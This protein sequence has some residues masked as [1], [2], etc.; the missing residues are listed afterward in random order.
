MHS[1]NPASS[2]AERVRLLL[3]LARLR[4]AGQRIWLVATDR[5]LVLLEED[6]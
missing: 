2:V 6:D 1:T 4:H 3:A 5:G